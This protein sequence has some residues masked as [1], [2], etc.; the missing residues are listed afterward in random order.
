MVQERVIYRLVRMY[1]NTAC[2]KT[3][4][5]VELLEF[6]GEFEKVAKSES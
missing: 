4:A 3:F 1:R 6:E 2:R 5:V